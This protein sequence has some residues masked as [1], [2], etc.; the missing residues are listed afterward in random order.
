MKSSIYS[1]N[2]ITAGPEYGKVSPVF[3][4]CFSAS[5]PVKSATL[6]I[7]A[8]GIYVAKLNGERVGDEY[9]TPG[10]T[11]YKSRLL[12]Q[13][14]DVTDMITGDNTL[15]VS[16]GRGWYC[17]RLG[18]L[19]GE[20][21]KYGQYPAL[22]CSLDIVY[23]DGKCET[24]ISDT[25]WQTARSEVLF[26]EIYDG[27][28]ADGRVIPEF[29]DSAK[30]FEYDKALLVP[31]DGEP[32][33][34]TERVAVRELIVTPRGEVVLDFGQNLTG[35]VEFVLESMTGGEEIHLE[36]AEILDRDGNFYNDNYR[37]A[38]GGYKYTAKPGWQV[39]KPM[40]TFF[41]FRY[42][43][44]SGLGKNIKP[45]NFTA[46][47]LCSDMKRTGFF[48]CQSE[49]IN[50]LYSNIIW[51]QRGNF[52]DIPTDCPQ[53]DERLGWTGDAQVFSTT[54]MQNFDTERF[55]TKWLRDMAAAQKDDGGV[56]YV[57]PNILPDE[58]TSSTGWS[59]AC[60][61][62]PWNL[63]LT[64]GNKKLL[65]EHL[66]MMKKW[67]GYIYRQ[68]G[69]RY[70]YNSGTHYGD[71]LGLD[72]TND[73]YTGSTDKFLIA[74]AYYYLSASIVAKACRELDMSSEKYES[75]AEKIRKAY[76]KKY[77]KRGRLTSDTQTA[78][79]LTLHFGLVDDNPELK[80][81]LAQHLIKLID[82]S[83]VSLKTGFIGTPYLLDTL[84]ECGRAD[85]AYEL[86]LREEYPSWLFSVR[87]GATTVWEHW[88]G[89]REDGSVWSTDMNSFNHY[90]YGSVASWFYGT[91]LGIKPT[92]A[93]YKRLTLAPIPSRKLGFAKG[94]LETRHGEIV[95]EWSYNGDTVR[96]SFVIPEGVKTI[97]KLPDGTER[98]LAAGSH[99]LW[100]KA[101]D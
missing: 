19:P 53:R 7:S 51:G 30:L 3:K 24:V 36:C 70:L 26:S 73:P 16:L 78:H 84:T 80:A 56:P 83:G 79:V 32:V 50:K 94:K 68:P 55:F 22:I 97:C 88:D 41:G 76:Q 39:C 37:T 62:V 6:N 48:K 49:M 91:I 58:F 43:R 38:K 82:D 66:P 60:C 17:S 61:I 54:A 35:Y 1:A 33:K 45:E 59:D 5:S 86:L 23:F 9:M 75:M 13:S 85:M 21:G 12:Y 96:F 93:A 27:E 90:A 18:F 20:G 46:V 47:V 44:V 57:I 65:R 8:L 99:T 69:G 71:W 101:Q 89:L 11:E 74:T 64:Y 72:F 40:F 42:I 52:L 63:Y 87:M 34:E 31:N 95:S 2:F 100:A 14:Y 98:I 28:I 81:K 29:K 10:W 67:V 92:E 15:E 25:S 77:I 4:K